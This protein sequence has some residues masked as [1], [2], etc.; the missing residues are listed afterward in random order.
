MSSSAT[1]CLRADGSMSM[2][3]RYRREVSASTSVDEILSYHD[4]SAEPS[5]ALSRF[6]RDGCGTVITLNGESVGEWDPKPTASYLRFV[7]A[8][9]YECSSIQSV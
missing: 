2:N 8:L 1:L 4:V 5:R 7:T 9:T 3:E 6:V